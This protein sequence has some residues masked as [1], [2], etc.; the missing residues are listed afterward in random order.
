MVGTCLKFLSIATT[1]SQGVAFPVE[2]I[3]RVP[4]VKQSYVERVVSC[5]WRI[6]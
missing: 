2:T 4:R 5:S 6:T 3:K 1:V